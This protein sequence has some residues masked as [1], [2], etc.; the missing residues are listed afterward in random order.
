M[1]I[2]AHRVLGTL[3]L[4]SAIALCS[5]TS[6]AQVP[7]QTAVFLV[8]TIQSD[9][10]TVQKPATLWDGAVDEDTVWIAI[11]AA[12][13]VPD[14][15]RLSV[16]AGPMVMEDDLPNA[17]IADSLGTWYQLP[18]SVLTN[19]RHSRNRARRRVLG[20]FLP[21]QLI[22]WALAN[23]HEK[24]YATRV[25]LDIWTRKSHVHAELGIAHAS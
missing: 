4:G 20:S 8:S 3:V 6:I 21:Q 10:A 19:I 24:P 1:C 14:S 16:R 2:A 18:A 12:S 25:G 5:A 17:S 13:G 23:L 7:D 9:G 11:N 15:M 22:D